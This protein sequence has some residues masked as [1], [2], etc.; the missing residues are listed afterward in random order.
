[1]Y[2]CILC[3]Y[4]YCIYINNDVRMRAEG[5]TGEGYVFNIWDARPPIREKLRD[6]SI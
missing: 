2:I 4:V 5:R 1:M 6:V 3:S